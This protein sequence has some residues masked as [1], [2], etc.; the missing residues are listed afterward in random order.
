MIIWSTKTNQ[1]R[2]NANYFN[3]FQVCL[4][5]MANREYLNLN[6]YKE[7]LDLY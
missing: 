2:I 6:T 4:Q 3:A 7:Q 1:T 5:N